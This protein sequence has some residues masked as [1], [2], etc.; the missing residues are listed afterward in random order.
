MKSLLSAAAAA[1]LV[2]LGAPAHGASFASA[3]LSDFTVT[4]FDLDAFDGIAPS[5]AYQL[6][7][8][9]PQNSYSQTSASDPATGSQ[10]ATGWSL[11]QFGPSSANS[12]AGLASAH[13][14]VSGTPSGGM[15]YTAS[16]AALGTLLSGS[17]TQFTASASTTNFSN[18]GF[19]LSPHTLAL[20]GGV[21]NLFAQ[22]TDGGNPFTGVTEN[23]SAFARLTVSGPGPGGSGF[24]NSGD[25]LSIFASFTFGFDPLTGQFIGTGQTMSLSGVSLSGSLTNFTTASMNGSVTL[26]LSVSGSSAVPPVPEPGSYALMLAGLSAVGLVVRRRRNR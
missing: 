3:T 20:F 11:V 6:P 18:L 1:S 5:I 22:T 26:N 7:N 16:G 25:N 19:V 14:A 21:A 2:V 4:L 12:A 23:A 15:S 8:F 24:Q 17:P 13:A 9:A 10:S